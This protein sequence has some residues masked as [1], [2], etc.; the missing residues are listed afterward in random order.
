MSSDKIVTQIVILIEILPQLAEKVKVD[1]IMPP[2]VSLPQI[3]EATSV[4]NVTVRSAA[5]VW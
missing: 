1:L 2:L 3:R 4:T 5:T